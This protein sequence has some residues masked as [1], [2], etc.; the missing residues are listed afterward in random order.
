MS[1]AETGLAE[2]RCAAGGSP[3][4]GA[5]KTVWAKNG[6]PAY[7]GV[8]LLYSVYNGVLVLYVVYALIYTTIC[9]TK[10]TLYVG[11]PFFR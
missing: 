8:L 11:F 1:A 10:T 6:S 7:R 3:P 4:L 5:G 9:T 2:N